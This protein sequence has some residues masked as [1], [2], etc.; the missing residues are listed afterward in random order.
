MKRSEGEDWLTW[1]A[2]RAAERLAAIPVALSPG[3]RLVGMPDLRAPTPE[4]TDEMERIQEVLKSIPPFPGGDAGHFHPDFEKLLR[5]GVRG[6]REEI[7]SRMEGSATCEQR[8]FFRACDA[9][10]QGL[11]VYARRVA[12]ACDRAASADERG[13]TAWRRLAAICRRV[14]TEAPASFHEAIELVFLTIIAL[15]YGEDHGLTTPGRM[16]Q[17]LRPFYEADLAAG[18]I[19]PGE[20]LDL[21]CCLYIQLN[22]ILMPGSAVSVMVGGRDRDGNDATNG[23][24]Y[25]CLAARM[26]TQLVYPTVGLAWHEGTPPELADFS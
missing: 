4:E 5:V 19:A 15:W 23:L 12:D 6:I 16:D 21:I 2:R 20:A 13:A 1:R 11:S 18:R 7:R 8:T 10:I 14:S 25:L 17:T 3:E 26:A 9:A 22:M 24:T